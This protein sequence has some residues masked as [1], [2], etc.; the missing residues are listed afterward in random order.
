MPNLAVHLVVVAV[1]ALHLHRLLRLW[2]APLGGHGAVRAGRRRLLRPR[3]HRA[4]LLGP[5]PAVDH[6]PRR[7]E[8]RHRPDPLCP[9]PLC[10]LPVRPLPPFLV[11]WV[12]L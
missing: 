6:A 4:P 8:R 2:R 11:A 9:Q 7:Q 12:L 3:P 10:H 1:P 5:L